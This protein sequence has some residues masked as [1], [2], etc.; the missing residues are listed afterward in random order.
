MDGGHLG[1]LGALAGWC[2]FYR[3][4]NIADPRPAYDKARKSL[5]NPTA[6]GTIGIS[7]VVVSIAVIPA[8]SYRTESRGRG[9][10]KLTPAPTRALYARFAAVTAPLQVGSEVM[11]MPLPSSRAG[12]RLRLSPIDVVWAALTPLLALILRDALVLSVKGAPLAVL[13]CA[14]SFAC[15]LIAFLAFRVGVGISRYFSVHDAISIISAV[16]AAGLTTT[17]VLFTFTRLDGIPRSIPL[18]QGLV[19][20]AGLLLTRGIMA[21]FNNGDQQAAPAEDAALEHIIMI[22]SSRLTALYIKLLQAHAP[23]QRQV[24]AVL[25]DRPKL[26]GRTMCGVP[27]VGSPL[28]LDSIIDEFA[29]HGIRADRVLIGGDE[30]LLSAAALNELRSICVQRELAVDFVPK[31]LV[32]APALRRAV[33]LHTPAA[34]DRAAV[35]MSNYFRYKRAIDFIIALF[36]IAVVSPLF[37]VVAVLVLL[38]LGTPLVFWQK[39]IGRNGRS[40]LLYKFRTLQAS[41]DRNGAP[42]G[43][44]DYN[45]WIGKFLRRLRLDEL[46]Q[47]FNVLVGEMSLIGPRPLLPEDQPT[48]CQLRL[49]VRPGITGWAQINGGTLITTEEKGALDDWY[50]R[51][52]SFWLDLRIAFY[53]V[54]FLFSGERRSEQAVHQAVMQQIKALQQRGLYHK[55]PIAERAELR[56]TSTA[57]SQAPVRLPLS[58]RARAA[59]SRR[60]FAD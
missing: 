18:I 5:K 34:N 48:N 4:R 30:S 1:I 41:F 53:T 7:L 35:T 29:P 16:V 57:R 3:L 52:A 8:T 12:F 40:F 2:W 39:R 10:F 15:T 46:P 42:N 56:E 43:N 23:A 59:R 9:L 58:A 36:T 54:V 20:A 47:L 60:A 28:Q 26:L 11:P 33:P 44:G 6:P 49:L 19:L 51:N 31:L 37:A 17:V 22:G 21:K 27:V 55:P 38:D 45:S 50:V 13:Y 25:D 24:I 14:V 32:T